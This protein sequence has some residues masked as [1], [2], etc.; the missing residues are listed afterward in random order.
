MFPNLF[1]GLKTPHKNDESI[2]N[3]EGGKSIS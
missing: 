3:A 2:K 1:S